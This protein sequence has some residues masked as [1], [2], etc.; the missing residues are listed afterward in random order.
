MPQIVLTEDQARIVAASTES[1]EVIDRQGRVISFLTP[2][3]P[4]LAETI[5]ECTCR[6][7]SL[8]D[9]RSSILLAL[10]AESSLPSF[11]M[12]ISSL[13]RMVCPCQRDYSKWLSRGGTEPERASHGF[14]LEMC[15]MPQS[16]P[17]S[18]QPARP[19]DSMSSMPDRPDRSSGA[20][21]RCGQGSAPNR[22]ACSLPASSLRPACVG[23]SR[24]KDP[25]EHKYANRPA[26]G[27]CSDALVSAPTDPPAPRHS[28][29]D[30]GGRHPGS[31]RR[32]SGDRQFHHH[33]TE[34]LAGSRPDPGVSVPVRF[35]VCRHHVPRFCGNE[36]FVAALPNRKTI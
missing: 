34:T 13:V 20:S 3:D 11:L 21:H 5:E 32:R 6:L 8:W 1:V 31:R 10:S 2:F 17:A 9:N 23:T 28:H 29:H 16:V 36:L 30:T 19:T 27:S 35:R 7:A 33:A 22:T 24:F 4:I 18:G 15:W 12:P 25:G 26:S 14:D